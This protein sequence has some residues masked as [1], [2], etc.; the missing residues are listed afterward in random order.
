MNCIRKLLDV[1]A[2]VTG[3]DLRIVEP[4]GDRKQS[5]PNSFFHASVI[6]DEGT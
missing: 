6:T 4:D 2:G 1:R 3:T 5:R